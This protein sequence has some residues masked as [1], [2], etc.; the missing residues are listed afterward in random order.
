MVNIG[1]YTKASSSFLKASDVLKSATKIFTITS[2]GEMVEKEFEGKKSTK[3]QVEGEM[4][5][6]PY[7]FDVSK[8]NARVIEQVLGTDTKKWLG[9]QLILE[10]YKTKNSKNLLV[11]AINIKEAKK[12]V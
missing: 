11:D 1:D 5:K 4:D 6:V 2:E 7:K 8:T 9:S 10:T 3:L 12:I